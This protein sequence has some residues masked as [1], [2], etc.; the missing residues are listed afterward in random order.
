MKLAT[1]VNEYHHN[2][3]QEKQGFQVAN[4]VHMMK[5]LSDTL[6]KDKIKAVIRELSTNAYDAHVSNGCADTPFS[7]HFPT[8]QETFFSIRDYGTGLSKDKIF[9]LYTIYGVSDKSNSNDYVG[10]MGIGS[11]SPFAYTNSFQTISYYNGT[12]YTFLNSIDAMGRPTC[13]LMDSIDTFQPNG[14]EIIFDVKDDDI[15][16]FIRKGELV[17]NFFNTRPITNIKLHF[18]NTYHADY[19]GPTVHKNTNWKLFSRLTNES[20]NTSIIMGNVCYPIEKEHFDAKHLRMLE[21]NFCIEVPIGS[22]HMDASREGLQYTDLT[23]NTIKK[24]LDKIIYFFENKIEQQINNNT[25]DF[26]KQIC[27]NKLYYNDNIFRV[28][29][30]SSKNYEYKDIHFNSDKFD[31]TRFDIKTNMN[32]ISAGNYNTTRIPATNKKCVFIIN[33]GKNKGIKKVREISIKDQNCK[34]YLVNFVDKTEKN[35]IQIVKD[36]IGLDN[37]YVKLLSSY[38]NPTNTNQKPKQKGV[39]KC[40]SL[41][42]MNNPHRRYHNYINTEEIEDINDCTFYFLVKDSNGKYVNDY[43]VGFWSKIFYTTG[44]NQTIYLLTKK[45]YEKIKKLNNWIPATTLIDERIDNI[46]SKIKSRIEDGKHVSFCRKLSVSLPLVN[47]NSIFHKEVSKALSLSESCPYLS[48]MSTYVSINKKAEKICQ[49]MKKNDYGS[50]IVK[51]LN[52]RYPM[53]AFVNN[54][55]EYSDTSDFKKN[56][57]KIIADYVNFVDSKLGA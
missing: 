45:Q 47:K 54:R 57:K 25:C 21:H 53:L 1:K 40:S 16:K 35:K 56:T 15:M 12:K 38:P 2:G 42:R 52:S 48:E 41:I 20:S 28:I 8:T 36:T 37:K 3:I 33:D 49:D 30:L 26:D 7:V 18:D 11:K 34:Y 44:T 5:I 39:F 6:Y 29:I 17:Y 24:Q 13:H 19:Y 14:L 43:S 55:M 32:F 31:V 51:T 27:I 9:D 4:S 10:C 46:A 50:K 22:V 23:V